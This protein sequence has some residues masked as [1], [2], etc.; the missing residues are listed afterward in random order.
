MTRY[1]FLIFYQSILNNLEKSQ[2]RSSPLMPRQ[3]GVPGAG[4]QGVDVDACAG[5]RGAD[6]D[7]AIGGA[8][9][10]PRV[11]EQVLP[12]VPGCNVLT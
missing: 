3:Q 2:H 7:P 12:E 11:L 4:A 10:L 5:A 1:T 6:H 9:R 8:A